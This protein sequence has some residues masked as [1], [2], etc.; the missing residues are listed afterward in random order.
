[1]AVSTYA[2]R[3]L[4]LEGISFVRVQEGDDIVRV[5]GHEICVDGDERW[6]T[7]FNIELNGRWRHRSTAV[8]VT[9]ASGTSDL[10]LDG[11]RGEDVVDIAGSPFT[12]ALVLR[13]RDVPV[14]GVIEVRAAFIEVPALTVRPLAQRYRRLATD[15]WEYADDEFGAFEITVDADRVT[16]DYERLATRLG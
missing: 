3:R 6:S 10:R 11:P 15:R 2:W 16:L 12:N 1:M 14:G 13:S 8:E 4:D 7:R 5:E 9:T